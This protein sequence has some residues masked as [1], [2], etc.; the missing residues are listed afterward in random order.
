MAVEKHVVIDTNVLVSALLTNQQSPPVDIMQLVR[1]GILAVCY[2]ER[3]MAEY[4]DVLLRPSFGF[5]PTEL[6]AILRPIRR[7]GIDV[8]P[9]PLEQKT[10]D[11]DDQAFYE[12]ASLC[13]CPLVTGNKRHYPDEPHIM[14]PAE[15]LAA[16]REG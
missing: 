6:R 11:P 1:S 9:F 4:L 14:T 13:F 8:Y 7:F 15:Y 3:I 2:D 12:V 5:D 10:E 16:M